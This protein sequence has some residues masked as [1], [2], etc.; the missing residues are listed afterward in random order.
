MQLASQKAEQ[1]TEDEIRGAALVVAH[2]DDE[3]LW[4]SSLI[5]R[6][7]QTIMCFLDV[8]SDPECSEGRR[9]VLP[10]LP[11]LNVQT[12][13]LQEAEVYG[14][15]NWSAPEITPTGMGVS[16]RRSVMSGY[17]SRRY[18]RN[19]FQL[20]ADLRSALTGRRIVFTHNPWGEYGHEEH[21]QV[22]RVVESLQRELGFRLFFTTYVS[23]RSL[24]LF[25]RYLT[26]LNGPGFA[27]S[28]NAILAERVKSLYVEQGCWTWFDNYTWPESDH[29]IE[30][31][32]SD[33][34]I[35]A[36]VIV[37]CRMIALDWKP[38]GLG[39]TLDGRGLQ[40]WLR[41]LKAAGRALR[42]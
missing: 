5:D 42:G 18:T 22:F 33:N 14:A 16:R 2:P 38:R 3:I 29:F 35:R 31:V 20:H 9:R 21:V 19:F 24:V 7:S 12:L 4:F 27:L 36:G 13:G 8:A 17:S 23:G 1:L 32:G 25:G 30:W 28:A 40:Q 34:S 37:P 6:V 41:R 11:L 10:Q 15:G 26:N 39:P